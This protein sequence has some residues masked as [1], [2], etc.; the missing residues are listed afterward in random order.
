MW[1]A[2][3]EHLGAKNRMTDQLETIGLILRILA[4]MT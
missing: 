1:C 4:Y 3:G 2:S